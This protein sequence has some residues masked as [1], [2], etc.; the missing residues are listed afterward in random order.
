MKLGDGMRSLVSLVVRR[1][2]APRRVRPA[3]ELMS[4]GDVVNIGVAY[5]LER[6]TTPVSDG[7]EV[8]VVVHD[9]TG[10]VRKSR[11]SA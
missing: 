10:E 3:Y 2:F 1:A 8:G 9:C 7:K 6:W 11:V 4:F 5:R